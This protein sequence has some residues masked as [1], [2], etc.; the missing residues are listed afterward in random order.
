MNG[1]EVGIGNNSLRDL[2]LVM[3][4][5]ALGLGHAA[6]H[7][8]VYLAGIKNVFVVGLIDQSGNTGHETSIFPSKL[9]T[10]RPGKFDTIN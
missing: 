6:T 10:M 1:P 8:A 5:T 7:V 9:C 2:S 4:A 3:D